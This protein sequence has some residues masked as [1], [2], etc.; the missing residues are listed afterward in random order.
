MTNDD[1]SERD[2]LFIALG[3][4]TASLLPLCQLVEDNVSFKVQG[5][6]GKAFGEL[7]K[8]CIAAQKVVDK[9]L[10]KVRKEFD[11]VKQR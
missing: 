5:E 8:T 1:L 7:L 3:I 6:Y 4:L 2:A 10:A 9:G 11:K